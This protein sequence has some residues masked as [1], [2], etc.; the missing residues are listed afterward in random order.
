MHDK[1]LTQNATLALLMTAATDEYLV[2]GTRGM[3]MLM[4]NY[5]YKHTAESLYRIMYGDKNKKIDKRWGEYKS[6]QQSLRRLENLKYLTI[7]NGKDLFNP[8]AEFTLNL[9]SADLELLEGIEEL[10]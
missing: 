6:I 7:S 10:A 5:P 1:Q 4:L 8:D 9:E 2:G 3:L